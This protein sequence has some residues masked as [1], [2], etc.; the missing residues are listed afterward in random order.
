M[1]IAP[2]ALALATGLLAIAPLS[3]AG[4]SGRGLQW[5]FVRFGP[6]NGP[7]PVPGDAWYTFDLYFTAGSASAQISGMNMGITSITPYF[8]ATDGTVF[9]HPFGGDGPPNPVFLPAFPALEF[10]TYLALGDTL[11]AFV[12][13][14]VDLSGNGGMLRGAWFT[15]PPIELLANE[16]LRI[17]RVTVGDDTTFLGGSG[18]QL[19]VNF[20]GFEQVFSIPPVQSVPT[21]G[22]ALALGLASLVA[23]RR[24]RG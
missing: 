24:R 19:E 14:S 11:P 3:H 5:E 9:N 13:G 15:Q 12:G 6:L 7:S 10:D 21:P 17:L 20:V 16:R 4:I 22:G 18:S 2:P 8:L 23:A 1:R